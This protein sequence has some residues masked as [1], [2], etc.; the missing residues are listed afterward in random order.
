MATKLLPARLFLALAAAA[1]AAGCGV[2]G[3]PEL[4]A[5]KADNFPRTYPEGA[6]PSEVRPTNVLI[7][8]WR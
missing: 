5:D 1:L 8:K 2:K 4:P 6:T 3:V 7:D